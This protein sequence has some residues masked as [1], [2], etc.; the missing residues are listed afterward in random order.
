MWP[1]SVLPEP[2]PDDLGWQAV[3]KSMPE[4]AARL[5][6]WRRNRG[7]VARTRSGLRPMAMR[8]EPWPRLALGRGTIWSGFIGPVSLCGAAR[9]ES[10]SG[11]LSWASSQIPPYVAPF[12]YLS[13]STSASS[14]LLVLSPLC[15]AHCRHPLQSSILPSCRHWTSQALTSPSASVPRRSTSA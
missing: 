1:L 3:P 9:R 10:A 12:P 5:W 8:G 15:K 2:A 11:A 14:L 13:P 6:P 7:C 4:T